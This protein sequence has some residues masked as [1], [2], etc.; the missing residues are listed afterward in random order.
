MA[1]LTASQDETTI[2]IKGSST[3][4]T[5]TPGTLDKYYIQALSP[6]HG[7]NVN[8]DAAKNADLVLD[9]LTPGEEYTTTV[10]TKID[11]CGGKNST[12]FSEVTVCTSELTSISKQFVM[13]VTTFK[14]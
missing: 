12:E 8:K 1:S 7:N 5:A 11:G 13:S 9:G 3:E 6:S 10:G 14:I 4:V 2:T